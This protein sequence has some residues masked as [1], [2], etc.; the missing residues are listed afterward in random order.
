MSTVRVVFLKK[1][2]M[3]LLGFDLVFS[4][5]GAGARLLLFDTGVALLVRVA[6][7]FGILRL[8]P[9][10]TQDIFWAVTG[11]GVGGRPVE[12][13]GGEVFASGE[14]R[15]RGWRNMEIG[16]L[17]GK[18]KHVKLIQVPSVVPSV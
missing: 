7:A 17:G 3:L 6:L 12:G 13:L 18:S 15:T 9:T 16:D 11:S 14:A 4:D 2:R 10:E 1:F 8:L 5:V